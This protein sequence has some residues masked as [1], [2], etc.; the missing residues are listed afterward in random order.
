[1]TQ[2][3]RFFFTAA[4][5]QNIKLSSATIVD[6]PFSPD[7]VRSSSTP[8]YPQS[9][10]ASFELFDVSAPPQVHPLMGGMLQFIADPNA[11]GGLPNL[12]LNEGQ[13]WTA[14]EYVTWRVQGSLLVR[15]AQLG[16]NSGD[17][18][19]GS[20]ATQLVIKPTRIWYRNVVL[21]QEFLF[22]TLPNALA[23]QDI[24]GPGVTLLPRGGDTQPGDPNPDRPW[25]RRVVYEFLRGR[26]IVRYDPSQTLA[27]PVVA[28]GAAF[29]RRELGIAA[30]ATETVVRDDVPYVLHDE[31]DPFDVVNGAIPARHVYRVLASAMS[32]VSGAGTE[33]AQRVLSLDPSSPQYDP[34]APSYARI[35]FTRTWKAYLNQNTPIIAF[36]KLFEGRVARVEGISPATIDQRMPLHGV[37]WIPVSPPPPAPGA[38]LTVTVFEGAVANPPL[39]NILDA[40]NYPEPWKSPAPALPVQVYVPLPG[41][42]A[43]I[44]VR[45][46]LR[47]EVLKQFGPFP[48]TDERSVIGGGACTYFTLRRFLR[49]FVDHRITGGGLNGEVIWGGRNS[50]STLQLLMDVSQVLHDRLQNDAPSWFDSKNGA[51]ALL[52]VMNT[53][54]PDLTDDCHQD[55]NLPNTTRAADT[56]FSKGRAAYY[57]WQTIVERF[58]SNDELRNY[59]PTDIGR[60][61]C[62]A[63]RLLGLASISDALPELTPLPP[64]AVPTG[65]ALEDVLSRGVDDV[66]WEAEP[67]DFIQ[68]W[69]EPRL[70]FDAFSGNAGAFRPPCYNPLYSGCAFPNFGHSVVFYRNN[71]GDPLTVTM[72]DQ[73][74]V[75]APTRY[76]LADDGVTR[77][78]WR[79]HLSGESPR[80]GFAATKVWIRAQLN[81]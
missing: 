57:L 34:A 47:D 35:H 38:Q 2:P 3:F 15:T 61:A 17:D 41:A 66:V 55:W 63:L 64:Q 23:K 5:Q 39:M 36:N 54:W 44:I 52:S 58:D 56:R 21:T 62:G 31:N 16:S 45:G 4:D 72:I 13:F 77:L 20:H 75:A 78:L 22:E 50:A 18:V 26:Y 79:Y 29:G 60:G 30:A 46:K 19:F 24:I 33:F 7:P 40:D 27:M 28:E 43:H 68:F 74:G 73:S 48:T 67:G 81:E 8:D 65:A 80:K 76:D 69:A 49:A 53:L 42:H 6:A 1:M 59:K 11:P 25:A 9:L 32:D 10:V 14:S 51:G 37:L 70:L 12:A 71:G